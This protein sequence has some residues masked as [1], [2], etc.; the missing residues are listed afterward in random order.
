M[1]SIIIRK[2][3]SKIDL[4]INIW[5][6]KLAIV[7][8]WHNLPESFSSTLAL[9]YSIYITADKVETTQMLCKT[10]AN[11]LLSIQCF[12]SYRENVNDYK[13]SSLGKKSAATIYLQVKKNP[14]P[15]TVLDWNLSTSW[16]PVIH[17]MTKMHYFV[18]HF[19]GFSYEF[20]CTFFIFI[21]ALQH[22]IWVDQLQ[23]SS[24]HL[25]K[26]IIHFSSL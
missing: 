6:F 18:H 12:Y 14:Q 20:H 11:V 21:S 19:N 17:S 8:W 10:A 9:F 1:Q 13:I 16:Y 26:P 7:I 5:K 3:N 22:Y 4:T 23:A 25:L 2:I 24:K 15:N